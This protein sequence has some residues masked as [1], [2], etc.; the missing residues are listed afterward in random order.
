[1]LRKIKKMENEMN[2]ELM[3]FGDVDLEER[4]DLEKDNIK[5][6]L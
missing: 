3:T 1:M 6:K 5:K 4:E 2:R